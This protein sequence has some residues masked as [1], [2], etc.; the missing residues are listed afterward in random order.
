[1]TDKDEPFLS[2]W[3]R[4]KREAEKGAQRPTEVAATEE[5]AASAANSSGQVQHSQ[6]DPSETVDGAEAQTEDRQ[7]ALDIESIDFDK[8]DAHSDY[9][10]FMSAKVPDEV[11]NKAL[12][13][14]W[15][16]D[17]VLSGP[18]QLSD[19]MDDFTDAAC[20]VP[21]GLLRTAYKVGQG[22]LSDEEAAEWDRLGRTAPKA[23]QPAQETTEV[24]VR[25]E[26]P[27]Q[28][29]IAAFLAASDAYAESL[30]PPESNHMVDLAALMAPN[31][32]F[33]VARQGEKA[34]GC[35]ALIIGEDG[36]GEVK[37]M[38]VDPEA[39]GQ[40]I[41]HKILDAIEGAAREKGLTILRLETGIR[42]PEAIALYRKRGFNE[43]APFG[44][45]LAD[46]LSLFMEKR[47]A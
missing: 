4:L 35:G 15:L 33:F 23:P 21:S 45:Y 12:N 20:A 29:E 41:G 39:R 25:T 34:L 2:R 27:D 30:Y 10:P 8:L 1:M 9:K 28:P 43:C 18:D 19:Y 16:S 47:L 26:S 13:K 3:S 42:Q 31:T 40:G 7:S 24:A 17:P 44:S 11:R 46:P 38:W 32:V 37:R 22:F 6:A 5:G 14:L 36:S